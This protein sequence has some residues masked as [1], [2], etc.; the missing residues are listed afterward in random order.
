MGGE[1]LS[2]EVCIQSFPLE[3]SMRVQEE[4]KWSDPERRVAMGRHGQ[5]YRKG[6]AG[7]GG[8]SCLSILQGSPGD[9]LNQGSPG[10]AASGMF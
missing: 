6:R 10:L 7:L 4:R 1:W 9:K 8:E 5:G 3:K 2:K